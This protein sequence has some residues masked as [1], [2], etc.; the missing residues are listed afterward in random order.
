MKI[1]LF[2][3][4]KLIGKIL[5]NNIYDIAIVGFG[6]TGV[7]FLKYIQSFLHEQ[8]ISDLKIA[9]ISDQ[10]TFAR[11]RAFGDAEDVH[12]VNTPPSMMSIQLEDPNGFVHW[13]AQMGIKE[14]YPSRLLYAQYLQEIFNEIQKD[15]F[16]N[17]NCIYQQAIDIESID[18]ELSKIV[19]EDETWLYARQVVLSIGAVHDTPYQQIKDR[20]L[21]PNQIKHHSFKSV[22]H[23]V[24]AGTGLTAIDCIRSLKH[25]GIEK[26]YVFSRNNKLPT[27][28][29]TFNR[30]S[31]QI[32]IWSNIKK[33]LI[34][35]K[36]GRRLRKLIVLLAKEFKLLDKNE[37][38]IA[39]HLIKQ[40]RY[41]EYFD[42]VIDQANHG[43]MVVQDILVSTRHYA[44]KIW[45]MLSDEER[46]VFH[47]KYNALWAVWRHP[48]PIFVIEDLAKFVK[49]KT[50]EIISVSRIEQDGQNVLIICK[51]GRVIDVPYLV[52]GTGGSSQI[53]N[54]ENVLVRNLL[55]KNMAQVHPCGGIKVNTLNFRVIHS[56][57]FQKLY[58]LG[59]L[60]KGSLFSTNA[61]WYNSKCASELAYLLVHNLTLE[62]E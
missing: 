49:Q 20:I 57:P 29:T 12:R 62:K 4:K 54:T 14:K 37:F 41:T 46:L 1:T 60:A 2:F 23:V 38:L 18:E 55:D 42:F 10:Q 17:L 19:L 44:H 32:F 8:S 21:L 13:L 58:C 22:P 53:A 52:D 61:F 26:I 15:T 9:V 7:S 34:N 45:K 59:Q 16:F 30:Y 28:I 33:E 48:V 40:Q 6:A 27:P 43:E 50:I 11:G 39:E 35:T 3:R 56:Q 31:P 5:K 25:K 36:S 51:D 47:E 24:V